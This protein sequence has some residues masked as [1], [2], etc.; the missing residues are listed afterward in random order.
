MFYNLTQKRPG[1]SWRD[2]LEELRKARQEYHSLE[3]MMSPVE[4]TLFSKSINEKRAEV[5]PYIMREA[6]GEWHYAI[7]QYTQAVKGLKEAK[8]REVARWDASKLNAEMQT[9]ELLVTKAVQSSVG[10][11]LDPSVMPRLKA[12]YEEAKNSG[13]LYKAR[14]CAEV[15]TGLT[16][17]VGNDGEARFLANRLSQQAQRD[18]KA[19]RTTA[20]L[21]RS[22]RQAEEAV[23]KLDQ[24]K[25]T[26][27]NVDEGLGYQQFNGGVGD[28]NIYKE[29]NRVRVNHV[30]E[31]IEIVPIEQALTD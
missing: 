16:A 10:G 26:L 14:A 5:E 18:A 8:N 24:A 15:F 19:V 23:E 7:D 21:E 28:F 3:G 29:L 6:L 13:D 27:I 9:V 31:V 12:M 22:D 1:A 4:R 25:H 17:M 11:N 20:E 30:G 2:R